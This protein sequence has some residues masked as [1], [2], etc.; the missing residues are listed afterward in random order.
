MS[1]I[2][3]AGG[4]IYGLMTAASIRAYAHD[5]ALESAQTLGI[6]LADAIL[7][8]NQSALR[9]RGEAAAATI[10]ALGAGT[11]EPGVDESVVRDQA[12]RFFD[13]QRIGEA[14]YFFVVDSDGDVLY[15][16]FQSVAEQ[17]QSES[18]IV[19]R[20]IAQGRGFVR[21]YWQNPGEPAPQ[22]K[23]G[24]ITHFAPWDWY[25]VATDYASGFLER[26]PSTTLQSLL[27]G[28][29]QESIHAAFVVR[30][31]RTI[32]G[33]SSGWNA[34]ADVAERHL[35]SGRSLPL[36]ERV[37]ELPGGDL[38]AFAPLQGFDAEAGVVFRMERLD[39]LLS[40][41][42]YIVAFSLL[43]G[44]LVIWVSSR[45]AGQYIAKPIRSLS[46]RLTRRLA[47]ERSA[48]QSSEPDDLR[49]LILQQL[50]ALVRLDYET[51]GRH[52]A[53]REAVVAESVFRHTTE[54]IIVTD[55]EGVIIRVNPALE[56]I[57]GYPAAELVGRNPRMLKS[58]RHGQDFY[59]TLWNTLESTGVWVGEIWNRRKS[60]EE[61][62]Q[63][64]SIRAV[65]SEAGGDIDSYV[66]V[67]HDISERKE[68]E[69]RLHHLATHDSL[70]G[71][72]NR[73]YLNDVLAQT[74]RH[75]ERHESITAVLFL[76]IDDFKD[77]NDSYGHDSG[78]QLLKWIARRLEFQLRSEDIVVRFGGD[79]FVIV[80][81]QIEDSEYASVVA[82]RI[83]ASAREPYLIEHQKIR[84]SVSIGIAI[85]PEAGRDA[86][87]LLRD[88]DA[89]MYT[90]KRQGRNTYRFH[91]PGMNENAHRRLAMQGSIAS[92]IDKG[93]LSVVY[94]PILALA[95]NRIAG[96][97]ALVRWT[98]DGRLISPGEFLPFLE[99]SSMLTRLDL[100]V[101]D[102]VCLEINTLDSEHSGTFFISVNAG[103]YNLIQDD[104]VHRVTET[105]A[106]NGVDPTRI[107]IEVTESAAIRNF[108][109]ARAT[110]RDLQSAGFRLYLDDF[111][112]GHSS[113]RYLREFGVDSVKLD[114][115]YLQNV[116]R[117]E[118]AR[119]LVSGFTQLAH[120]MRLE[121]VI[122]GVET[123]GQ[124]D[125]IRQAGCDYAQG[126][127][128]GRPGDLREAL[129]ADVGSLPSDRT[130]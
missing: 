82:R 16:P 92:A 110:L 69:E 26:L 89:A 115:A 125:F 64:L 56:A 111:G 96:A 1:A 95:D 65:R 19:R 13:A 78:D 90:A 30:P 85:Y 79:E 119:S 127:L 28:Y 59:R 14:G 100:W 46:R 48:A 72:P 61:Y 128:V 57:T 18:P 51:K 106:R 20:I 31:N 9:A 123:P 50:R 75:A 25:I 15:H 37:S 39:S 8:E 27:N 124:L 24:Y 117:S 109:R 29:E 6:T 84:P 129:R 121:A 41:Y 104:F 58:S 108:D 120:G 114:R 17:D 47:D 38:I 12:F 10:A 98:R 11:G 97:E 60:G 70:T 54:G 4:L 62:P 23:R 83:L 73:T 53:E 122:E 49:E 86:A 103:A 43:A 81:P 116:E 126:F 22:D 118:S 33:S 34:V 88:A 87:D 7:L 3:V 52:A 77:V 93:E 68:S 76:D 102:Q 80:L 36:D 101:L 44:V 55:A 67:C 40:R 130:E 35:P 105:V 94:Q 45:I 99:N 66:A 32:V 63:L 91:N 74:L 112:E 42:V 107:A 2:V 21:Y 71:L 113:I 5:E